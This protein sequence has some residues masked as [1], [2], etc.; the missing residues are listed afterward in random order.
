MMSVATSEL[1]PILI[2]AVQELDAK[3]K[4]LEAKP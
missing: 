3:I 1:I 2:K 4:I